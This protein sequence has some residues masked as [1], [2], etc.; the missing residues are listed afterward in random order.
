MTLNV[1]TQMSGR[2]VIR[3]YAHYLLLHMSLHFLCLRT[4][5]MNCKEMLIVAYWLAHF[6]ST[7]DDPD[8]I[9]HGAI[10]SISSN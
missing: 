3:T 7:V 5:L 6:T 9:N 8:L 4:Q 1:K 2:D 10:L